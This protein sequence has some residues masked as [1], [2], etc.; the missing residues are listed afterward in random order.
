MF[1]R[2]SLISRLRTPLLA[3]KVLVAL[4]RQK[5][6]KPEPL[7]EHGQISTRLEK[8]KGR[9]IPQ[10]GRANWPVRQSRPLV[11]PGEQ[12]R[13]TILRQ[14]LPPFGEQEAAS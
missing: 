12:E 6:G 11:E 9:G 2:I 1:I 14:R 3:A 13:Q 7:L 5:I 8:A 4:D 10:H